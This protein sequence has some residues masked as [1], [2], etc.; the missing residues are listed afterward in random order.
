MSRIIA[1][2]NQKGGVGKTTTAINLG[3]ALAREG[4]E[5]LLVD[6]DPQG[7]AS[8]GLGLVERDSVPTTYDV[9]TRGL[10]V[11]RA[12]HAFPERPRLH[13]VPANQDLVGAEVEL[14]N[15]RDRET[16]LRETLEPIRQD[17]DVILIDSPPSLGLLTLN[18]LTAADS[19]LIPIQCEYYALEGLAQLLNTIRL[20]QRS[21]N[22]QL[23]IEGVLL[24]MYDQRLSLSQQVAMEVKRYFGHRVYDTVITRNVSIAEAPGFGQAVAEH[25]PSSA[26][27]IRY[28]ALA[29]E[30]RARVLRDRGR[31]SSGG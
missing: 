3:S 19:V 20:V 9:L 28:A 27:A 4:T 29:R 10:P 6:I 15:V 2:A 24:T 26:G 13:L 5:V 25:E 16:L 23:E 18:G 22:P 14:V 1:L 8:S 17:Y 11:F 7:N 30:V 21:L 12:I 31:H